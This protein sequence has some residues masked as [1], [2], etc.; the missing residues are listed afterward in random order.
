MSIHRDAALRI[1]G[2]PDGLKTEQTPLWAR[3]ISLADSYDTMMS[4]RTYKEPYTPERIRE[5]LDKG[6]GTQFDPE[7]VDL[8]K[9]ILDEHVNTV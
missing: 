3:I 8:F 2:D 6:R 1:R 5:E 7:L 4:R 9:A